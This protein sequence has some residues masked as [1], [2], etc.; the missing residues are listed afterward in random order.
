MGII[1]ETLG[2][3]GTSFS[4]ETFWM[5]GGVWF[6]R[7]RGEGAEGAKR[8]AMERVVLEKKAR[9]PL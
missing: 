4:E 2:G 7:G 8:E 3:E 9:M 6:A 1:V 5:G